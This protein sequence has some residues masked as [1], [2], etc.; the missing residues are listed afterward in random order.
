MNR[1]YGASFDVDSRH[2]FADGAE[3]L[4]GHGANFAGDFERGDGFAARGADKDD[5]IA[6][7][8]AGDIGDVEQGQVHADVPD[9][10]GG[11]AADERPPSVRKRA[12]GPLVQQAA[13]APAAHRAPHRRHVPVG[14]RAGNLEGLGQG[15]LGRP[16]SSQHLP[17]GLDLF[18]WLGAEVG[19]GA[20][21][22]SAAF[23]EGLAQQHGGRGVAIGDNGDVHTH[24][25]MAL[26]EHIKRNIYMT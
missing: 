7:G 21:V 25:I 16:V 22:H 8:D 18:R 19:E 15:R 11:A 3:H 12:A 9:N 14:K 13:Q 23:A 24:I 5:L 4:I 20:V 6:H 10:R 26:S 2:A 1:P 17:Q